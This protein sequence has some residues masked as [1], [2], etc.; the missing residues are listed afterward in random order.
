MNDVAPRTRRHS[1]LVGHTEGDL[2]CPEVPFYAAHRAP[3]NKREEQKF[4]ALLKSG[5]TGYN[6]P[7]GLCGKIVYPLSELENATLNAMGAG[8]VDL[9]GDDIFPAETGCLLGEY[10]LSIMNSG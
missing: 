5:S 2:L 4:K 3:K 7:D 9:P 1:P 8:A 6:L 10:M